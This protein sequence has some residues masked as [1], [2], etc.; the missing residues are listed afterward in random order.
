MGTGVSRNRDGRTGSR[1]SRRAG[2]KS[3][4]CMACQRKVKGGS[5]KQTRT[6]LSF[7]G[8]GKTALDKHIAK[9][10]ANPR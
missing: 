3:L 8:K 2:T 9:V 10:H 6:V 5:G 7:R 4:T 1:V